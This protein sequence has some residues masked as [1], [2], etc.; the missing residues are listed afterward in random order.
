MNLDSINPQNLKNKNHNFVIVSKNQIQ[1][2]ISTLKSVKKSHLLIISDE[3]LISDRE[4][5]IIMQ[6]KIMD[7]YFVL[8]TKVYFYFILLKGFLNY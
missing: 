4:W 5:S 8:M 6:Q 2:V 7:N 3:P 1:N